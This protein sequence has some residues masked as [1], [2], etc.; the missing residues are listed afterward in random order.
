VKALLLFG[1]IVAAIQH[2]SHTDAVEEWQVRQ[3]HRLEC[4]VAL[5]NLDDQLVDRYCVTEPGSAAT[6]R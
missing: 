5:A 6:S 2:F 4:T 1:A 3:A